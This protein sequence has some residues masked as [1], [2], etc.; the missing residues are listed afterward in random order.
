VFTLGPLNCPPGG[1]EMARLFAFRSAPV[2]NDLTGRGPEK[3]AARH[4][5]SIEQALGFTNAM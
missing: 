3:F 1:A 5:R 2:K 4:G